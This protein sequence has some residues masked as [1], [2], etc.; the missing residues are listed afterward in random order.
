[1]S[2][3]G[4]ISSTSTQSFQGLSGPPRGRPPEPTAEMKAQFEAKFESAAKEA[5]LD[6]DKFKELHSKIKDAMDSARQNAQ[7]GTDMK[8]SMEEAMNGVLEE[9]GVD[10]AEFKSQMETVF[11]KM[12][13]PKPGEGGFRLRNGEAQNAGDS[14]SGLYANMPAGALFDAAA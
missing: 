12:G 1:M 11:S 14:A 10:P 6:V 13:M 9:A 4:N 7:P 5:G 3:I 2:S 8:A